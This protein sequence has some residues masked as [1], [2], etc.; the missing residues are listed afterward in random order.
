[1]ATRRAD[2]LEGLSRSEI[3]RASP[4]MFD[5]EL[6]EKLSRVHWSV[7]PILFVPTILILLI[8]GFVHGAGWMAA[9]WLPAAT[10][11]GR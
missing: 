2:D 6:L 11:S 4:R 8:E 5:S 9:V 7:P 10:C 3:L 1:M